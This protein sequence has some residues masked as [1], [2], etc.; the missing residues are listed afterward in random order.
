MWLSVGQAATIG[1]FLVLFGTFLY[2]SRAILLPVL[3]A[4]VI[5]LT[6]APLIKALER[7][8]IWI[9]GLFILAFGNADGLRLY[10]A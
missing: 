10:S 7:L 5:A 4:A 1:I 3:A 2:L 8:G 6:L 9:T